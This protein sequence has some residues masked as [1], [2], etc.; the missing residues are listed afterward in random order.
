VII[1]GNPVTGA[2]ALARY[3]Q[4]DKNERVTVL[5]VKGTVANDLHG[6]LME[7]DAYAEGTRCEK[8]LYHGKI[9]PSLLIR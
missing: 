5:E 1:K 3:L 9:S 8:A 6:A 2:A 7:M 4:N